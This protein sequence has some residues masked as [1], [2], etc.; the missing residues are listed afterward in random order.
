MDLLVNSVDVPI[1]KFHADVAGVAEG[2][3][4]EV[5]RVTSFRGSQFAE[6]TSGSTVVVALPSGDTWLLALLTVHQVR[7]APRGR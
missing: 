6:V 5:P 2:V 4:V 7:A 1:Q 3:M